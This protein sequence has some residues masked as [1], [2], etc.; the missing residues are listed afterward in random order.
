[1]K[2]QIT[3]QNNVTFLFNNNRLTEH[4]HL[5]EGGKHMPA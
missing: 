1:M 3:P 2:A 4:Q 5:F